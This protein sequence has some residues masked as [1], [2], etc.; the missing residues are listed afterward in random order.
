MELDI[1]SN[2]LILAWLQII[3]GLW[4][5]KHDP[6]KEIMIILG[7]IVASPNLFTFP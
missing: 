7:V 6:A 3:Y 5:L 1:L 4:V 2:A